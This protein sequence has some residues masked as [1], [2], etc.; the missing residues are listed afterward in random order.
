LL[1]HCHST[2]NVLQTTYLTPSLTH[3]I[4]DFACTRATS[5]TVARQMRAGQLLTAL[6]WVE[7]LA[8]LKDL[9]VQLDVL[10][11]GGTPFLLETLQLLHEL[12]TTVLHAVHVTHQCR[13]VCFQLGNL[14]HTNERAG[15]APPDADKSCSWSSSCAQHVS[16]WACDPLTPV[17]ADP[18]WLT[19]LLQNWMSSLDTSRLYADRSELC[20]AAHSPSVG[21][22]RQPR[23]IM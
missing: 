16:H 21:C 1:L 22:T 10:H 4:L 9:F 23:C 17:C 15:N 14:Q 2:H 13:L 6:T 7:G 3:G 11:A 12:R 5:I 18:A 19:A 20:C 8:Q